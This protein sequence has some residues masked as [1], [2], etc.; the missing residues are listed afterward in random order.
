[1]FVYIEQVIHERGGTRIELGVMA[2]NE[3]TVNFYEAA[4]Y[5][6]EE[7]VYDDTINTLT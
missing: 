1:L 6:R 5:N 3:R 2:E 7:E 4:G